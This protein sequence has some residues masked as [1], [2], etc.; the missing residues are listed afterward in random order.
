[1]S[2]LISQKKNG[3]EGASALNYEHE[4]ALCEGI[5]SVSEVQD[6]R[7]FFGIGSRKESGPKLTDCDKKI[8]EAKE[9]ANVCIE[10]DYKF[11]P[12]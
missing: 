3:F 2:G 7:L 9:K 6:S 1:M 10:S 11:C 12:E 4:V 8:L 5:I